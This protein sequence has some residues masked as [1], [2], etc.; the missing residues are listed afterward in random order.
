MIVALGPLGFD[1]VA[2]SVLEIH[3]FSVYE[4]E[5]KPAAKLEILKGKV[6]DVALPEAVPVHAKSPVPVP[7]IT[8]A[9]SV[10]PQV[11]GFVRVPKEIA[12]VGFIVTERVEDVVEHPF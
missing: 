8:I 4:I 2:E 1:K 7:E 12:G 11:V 6:I 10:P 9:P 3:P 5:Y